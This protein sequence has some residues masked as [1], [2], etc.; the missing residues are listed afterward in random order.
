LSENLEL[1]LIPSFEISDFK[2]II[3]NVP[4]LSI[5]ICSIVWFIIAM[6]L[7]FAKMGVFWVSLSYI[8]FMFMI[9]SSMA[10]FS[11]TGVI[12]DFRE[13]HSLLT[14]TLLGVTGLALILV[15]AIA[16]QQAFPEQITTLS[17]W[18]PFRT[19]D[20]EITELN[21]QFANV[22]INFEAF[23]QVLNIDSQKLTDSFT[24]LLLVAPGEELVF[25]G[26][27]PYLL[28][29]SLKSPWVGALMSNSVWASL[30][31]IQSYS[32]LEDMVLFILMAYVGGFWLLYMM[33]QVK[34]IT[35]PILI[36]GAYNVII[37]LQTQ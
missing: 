37:T 9:I 15:S 19:P 11:M 3:D 13:K 34:D 7:E 28:A 31:A 27:L 20:F 10:V 16:F 18:Q 12:T 24:N 32:Q 26:V 33:L 23:S 5:V 21:P 2:E 8:L 35:I 4:L 6:L 29:R 14:Y 25:R 1:K 17:L 22:Y 36:H 30:H